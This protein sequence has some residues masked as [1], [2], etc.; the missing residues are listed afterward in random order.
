[1]LTTWESVS[2]IVKIIRPIRDIEGLQR[3]KTHRKIRLL[4]FLDIK[5][6]K[7]NKQ[8][9]TDYTAGDCT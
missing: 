3:R 9:Y 8:V 6:K 5:K 7:I 1:M 4:K 2:S